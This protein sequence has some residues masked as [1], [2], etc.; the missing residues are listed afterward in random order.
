MKK[1]IGT[2]SFRKNIWVVQGFEPGPK[3][4]PEPLKKKKKRICKYNNN[5]IRETFVKKKNVGQINL[6]W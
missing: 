3:K 6:V 1:M 4:F 2:D 5:K